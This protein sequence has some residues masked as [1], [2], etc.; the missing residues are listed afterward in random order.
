MH[1]FNVALCDIKKVHTF[2]KKSCEKIL[3]QPLVSTFKNLVPSSQVHFCCVSLFYCLMFSFSV[4]FL[5]RA[6]TSKLVY[7]A[8]KL[9]LVVKNGCCELKP[10]GS[11]DS[12]GG[13][14]WSNP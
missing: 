3:D 8:T 10:R 1:F 11:S 12:L 6:R 2:Y 14:R 5:A 7:I 9:K 13:I 4:F